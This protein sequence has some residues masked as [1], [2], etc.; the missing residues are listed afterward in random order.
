MIEASSRGISLSNFAPISHNVNRAA[1]NNAT[2]AKVGAI[3]HDLTHA[4]VGVPAA[5]PTG[6]FAKP[7]SA[8]KL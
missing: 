3:K 2:A 8:A 7:P 5:G 6:T 1:G 4:S